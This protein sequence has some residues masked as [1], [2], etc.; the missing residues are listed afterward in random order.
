MPGNRANSHFER[1]WESCKFPL[2]SEHQTTVYCAFHLSNTKSYG[3]R[4][5]SFFAPTLWNTLTKNIRFSQSAST[6]KTTLKSHF[7]SNIALI[8]VGVCVCVCVCAYVRACVCVCVRAC[9]ACRARVCLIQPVSIALVG[10]VLY[11]CNCKSAMSS[12]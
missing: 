1:A 6:F 9:R 5:F 3:E 10:L 8:G 11:V 4:S 12:G 7:F 2:R